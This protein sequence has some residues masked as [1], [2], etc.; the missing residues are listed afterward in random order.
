[1]CSTC[2]A[3]PACLDQCNPPCMDCGSYLVS[4]ATVFSQGVC[5]SSA[6]PYSKAP[7]SI[8][9]LPDADARLNALAFRITA[10]QCMAGP[11]APT[12]GPGPTA[13]TA[14]VTTQLQ[15]VLAAA[16][17]V[18][19]FLN[20]TPNQV[21]WMR[22]EQMGLSGG[23]DPTTVL[24]PPFDTTAPTSSWL[25]HVVLLTGVSTSTGTFLARNSFGAGWGAGGRFA[26]S[27]DAL[28]SPALHSAIAIVS[29]CGPPPSAVAEVPTGPNPSTTCPLIRGDSSAGASSV[30]AG[31][32]SSGRR[33]SRK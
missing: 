7:A 23:A 19:V 8:N 27:I 10:M 13:S 25:G 31:G 14:S 20:L 11:G 29:T 5:L 12:T 18:V 26:I 1:V 3:N 16:W 24:M 28:V 21:A 17:P 30:V 15:A 6:W 32:A 4:A 2:A 9:E 33:T 22:A